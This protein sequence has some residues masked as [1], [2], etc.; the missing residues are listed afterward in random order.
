[1]SDKPEIGVSLASYLPW[2]AYWPITVSYWARKDGFNFLQALPFRGTATCFSWEFVL[3]IKFLEDAWNPTTIWSLIKKLQRKENQVPTLY[4]LLFFPNPEMSRTLFLKL[5]ESR[6]QIIVH[7][8]NEWGKNTL[9]EISPKINMGPKGVASLA[10]S[11][12]DPSLVVDTYHLRRNAHLGE[13]GMKLG[14]WEKSLP[15]LLPQTALIHVQPHREN[16]ELERILKGEE[17]ELRDMLRAIRDYG[18]KGPFLVEATLGI[19]GICIP[20]LRRMLR[21][22]RELVEKIF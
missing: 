14:Q 9:L 21:I 19:R 15:E 10:I 4:D 13:K 12:K 16:G 2:A 17:T 20:A 11:R 5:Q 8:V 1:M 22:M 3:P 7:S 6:P 18:Y